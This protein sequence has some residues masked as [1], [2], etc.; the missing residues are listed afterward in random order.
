MPMHLWEYP[1]W[2][3][4]LRRYILTA[5]KRRQYNRTMPDGYLTVQQVAARLEVNE[6]R[7]RA[8]IRAGKIKAERLGKRVLII[9]EEDLAAFELLRNRKAGRPKGS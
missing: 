1:S 9:K 8:L 7:V 2:P 4:W 5:S 3:D 6:S